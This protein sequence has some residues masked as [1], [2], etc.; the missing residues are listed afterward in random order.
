LGTTGGLEGGIAGEVSIRNLSKG[1]SILL[2]DCCVF[3][4]HLKK[5]QNLLQRR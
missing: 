1:S 2:E 5:S 3:F 4:V